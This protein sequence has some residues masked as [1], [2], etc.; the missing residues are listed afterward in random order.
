MREYEHCFVPG[1]TVVQSLRYGRT[2]GADSSAIQMNRTYPQQRKRPEG[3][4]QKDRAN[5]EV[6][7]E[8]KPKGARSGINLFRWT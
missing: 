2:F 3:V 1:S 6:G 4:C 7:R 8:P 5:R